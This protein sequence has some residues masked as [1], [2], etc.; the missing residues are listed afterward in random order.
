MKTIKRTATIFIA[1]L[2]FLSWSPEAQAGAAGLWIGQIAIDK[3]NEVGS[4]DTTTP[5]PVG[6]PFD[7]KMIVHSNASG[8][9]NLLREVI[10]MR[11]KSDQTSVLLTNTAAL[12]STDYEGVVTRDGKLVGKR[13]SSAFFDYDTTLKTLPLTG[14]FATGT[15]SGTLTLTKTHPTNPFRHRYHPDHKNDDASGITTTRDITISFAPVTTQNV[16]DVTGT[17]TETITGVHKIPIKLSGSITLN[18]VSTVS[19]LVP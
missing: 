19:T 2:F 15:I 13:L 12:S 17:Y 14:S 10:L 16:S 8:V 18:Q 7:M 5:K 9:V 6:K 11:Q 1:H 3:V 4:T